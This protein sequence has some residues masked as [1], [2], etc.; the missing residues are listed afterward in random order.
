M[1]SVRFNIISKNNTNTKRRD[2]QDQRLE[3][4]DKRFQDIRDFIL[5]K[6]EQNGYTKAEIQ[7]VKEN[8]K[9]IEQ[10]LRLLEQNSVTRKEVKDLE[11]KRQLHLELIRVVRLSSRELQLEVLKVKVKLKVKLAR[12]PQLIHQS[13]TYRIKS[14]PWK[15]KLHGLKLQ[16]LSMYS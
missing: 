11:L 13:W 8:K 4:G 1:L 14:K 6:K 7:E 12:H 15:L 5:V 3:E 10:R 9:T 16:V 2:K